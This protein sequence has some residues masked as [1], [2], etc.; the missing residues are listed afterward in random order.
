MCTQLNTRVWLQAS[1]MARSRAI[2]LLLPLTT[3]MDADFLA[4]PGRFGM[5]QD[6]HLLRLLQLD[7]E[8]VFHLAQRGEVLVELHLVG[9]PTSAIRAWR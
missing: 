7:C 6:S 3:S 2:A 5:T 8:L 1:A 4:S 9:R